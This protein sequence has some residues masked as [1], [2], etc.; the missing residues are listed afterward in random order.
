M[1]VSTRGYLLDTE[2]IRAQGFGQ[3]WE[4]ASQHGNRL[5]RPFGGIHEDS[6]CRAFSGLEIFDSFWAYSQKPCW[7]SVGENR[8]FVSF[9]SDYDCFFLLPS[10]FPGEYFEC[11]EMFNCLSYDLSLVLSEQ[12]W[13]LS[14]RRSSVGDDYQ[15]WGMVLY[16]LFP[17]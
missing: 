7:G 1:A 4:T 15:L 17:S 10:V 8:S 11:L 2:N 9:I 13:I 3:T 16:S 14:G 6:S 5:S 12:K